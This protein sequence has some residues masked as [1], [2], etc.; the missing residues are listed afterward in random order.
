M[1]HNEFNKQVWKP[2]VLTSPVPPVL[3]TCKNSESENV[4][5]VAWTGTV[6]THPPMT[7]ISVRPQRYSYEIIKQ[8]GVFAINLTTQNLTRACDFCGVKSGRNTDKFEK[9]SLIKQQA[10]KIDVPIIAQSPV[11]LECRVTQ[12]IPLG[13]HDMFLAEIVSLDVSE[14]L[15]DESLAAL[16]I[17]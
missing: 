3:V 8:S 4:F 17:L 7:Y 5:T 16:V 10:S 1:E 15:L 9:C 2:S 6:N 11:N 13:T 12:V 14:E